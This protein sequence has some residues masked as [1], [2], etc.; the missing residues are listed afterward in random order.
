[1][2]SLPPFPSHSGC[3]LA[4][5]L[6]RAASWQIAPADRGD[7]AFLRRLYRSTREDELAL[8]DWPEPAK[9]AFCDSQFDLQHIHFVRH[10]PQAQFL[11]IRHEDAPIGRLIVDDSGEA[12]HVVDIGLLPER[13]GQG[14][15]GALLRA[16]QSY[17]AETGR[18]V[19]L[20]VEQR[21]LRAQKLYRRLEFAAGEPG[22]THLP[23]SWT[24]R[25][26]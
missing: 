5:L 7:I 20:Q 8:T 2:T 10:F 1:L 22:P 23:M 3:V 25:K 21:N 11:V 6:S 18:S 9:A 13:R 24:P 19:K 15:G 17:A 4:E 12:V 26:P 16:L 14:I